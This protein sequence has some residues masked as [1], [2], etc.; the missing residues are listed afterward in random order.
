MSPHAPHFVYSL[1]PGGAFAP[2]G[3]RAALN[4]PLQDLARAGESPEKGALAVHRSAARALRTPTNNI[5]QWQL[6]RVR[7]IT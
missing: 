6:Q 5:R 4:D 2:S 3:G 1:P 7:R